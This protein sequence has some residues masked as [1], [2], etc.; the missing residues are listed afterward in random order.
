MARGDEDLNINWGRIPHCDTHV[1]PQGIIAIRNNLVQGV[2]TKGLGFPHH[3]TAIQRKEIS[4]MCLIKPTFTLKC[5][6]P[7]NNIDISE[8]ISAQV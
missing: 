8:K 2:N 5:F 4:C 6:V 7:N 3:F 1:P